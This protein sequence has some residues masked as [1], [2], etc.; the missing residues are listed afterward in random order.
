MLNIVDAG[1][2]AVSPFAQVG[3]V[4]LPGM[5][6]SVRVTRGRKHG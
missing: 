3:T 6:S 4:S 1:A 2:R 5:A